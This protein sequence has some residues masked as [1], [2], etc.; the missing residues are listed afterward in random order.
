MFKR[1]PKNFASS[2][3]PVETRT[4]ALLDILSTHNAATSFSEL[5]SSLLDF[6]L[7]HTAAKG[8][9]VL[10]LQKSNSSF[11]ERFHYSPKGGIDHLEPVTVKQDL[12]QP[13]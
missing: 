11:V 8:T 7:E 6:I 3:L 2:A 4:R 5:Q 10:T 9:I 1:K 12:L 13:W